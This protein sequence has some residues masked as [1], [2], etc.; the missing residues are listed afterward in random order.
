MLDTD[1]TL[2]TR[3]I[4]REIPADILY[5]DD[6]CIVINDIAPQ[7]PVHMLVI[8]KQVIPRL[9]DASCEDQP[10]LGHLMWVAAEVARD[11]GVDEAFRLVVNNGEGAG[12]TVFHLHVHVLAGSK[13]SPM[14]SEADIG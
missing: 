4:N 10:I 14:F 9:A 6:L 13:G 11:A 1:A 7:A 5:E 3:I 12:Q 8:P 2:F